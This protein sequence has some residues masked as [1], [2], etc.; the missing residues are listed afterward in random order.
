MLVR[1]ST[2]FHLVFQLCDAVL[3]GDAADSLISQTLTTLHHF[4]AWIPPAYVFETNLID[5]LTDKVLI[6]L[7]KMFGFCFLICS[8]FSSLAYMQY[9]QVTRFRNQAL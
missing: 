1:F 5:I 4:L 3:K 9:F 7:Q 2:D 6:S 8:F